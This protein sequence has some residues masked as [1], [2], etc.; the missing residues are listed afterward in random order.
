VSDTANATPESR[1]RELTVC[2]LFQDEFPWDVRADKILRSLASNGIQAHVIARN[3]GRAPRQERLGP[4]LY[5]HRLPAIGG[6]RMTALMNFPA[7]F[8][9]FWLHTSSSTVRSTAANLL[10]VRDLPLTPTA[11]VVGR[12]HG[13]PVVMDMAE[14]YPAMIQDT[15]TFRGATL[16]DRL[17]RNP[18]LLRRL[19]RV[20]VPRLDG[21]IVVSEHSRRRVERLGAKPESIWVVGNTPTLER[22]S[23]VDP[24]QDRL[25]TGANGTGRGLCLLYVG[26]LEESRGL[27]VVVRAMPAIL[28][29][30]PA[31]KF[32]IAGRGSSEQ[33]LKA[34]AASLGVQDSVNFR[35]WVA[36][37]Q[38]PS[39]IRS[40]DVCLVPHRV[41]EHV[42]TTVP[43][44]IFD[45][46]A[47]AKPVVVTNA[48]ALREIVEP[49]SCGEVVP[50]GD[51]T[52]M[53][54][55]V[56][57]LVDPAVRAK[58]GAAGRRAVLERYNWPLDERVLLSLV[59][60][61][62]K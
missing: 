25:P 51:P 4:N 57:R 27:D 45:Y 59:R 55:A 53:A 61:L 37:E 41:T 44:K 49:A 54:A 50:D 6:R 26:G 2:Y 60:R 20:V 58:Q 9:P 23:K 43:N 13:I 14:D 46:M 17:I 12:R 16:L 7:F 39:L 34:L 29:A 28:R 24:G 48:A 38:I 56:L 32:Q 22:I 10:L 21:I 18:R 8:S 62:A 52:A 31:A 5:A 33:S 30:E 36:P 11:L 1:T 3:R 35:G 15:W 19:E 40:A 47:Q 42:S